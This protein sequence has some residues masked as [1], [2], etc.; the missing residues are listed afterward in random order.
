MAKEKPR[1]RQAGRRTP[2][3]LTRRGDEELL[4]LPAVGKTGQPVA[5]GATGPRGPGGPAPAPG[6]ALKTAAKTA[7]GLPGKYFAWMERKNK[8]VAEAEARMRAAGPAQGT[9]GP[10][11][12]PRPTPAQG[13][14]AQP[15]EP[16][17]RAHLAHLFD[18]MAMVFGGGGPQQG[19]PPV[20][21]APQGKQSK[22]KAQQPQVR[23]PNIE[24]TMERAMRDI[25]S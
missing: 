24:E 23:Q 8:E 1:I 2:N 6:S 12:P 17:S 22:K 20:Q 19:P 14:Q 16:P 10:P 13:Q 21:R 5:H 25:F 15:Q 11:L 18:P 3:E 7:A 9:R 4:P